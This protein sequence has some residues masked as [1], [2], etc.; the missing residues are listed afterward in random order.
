MGLLS[1]WLESLDYDYNILPHCSRHQSPRSSCTNCIDSCPENAIQLVNGKPKINS[2]KCTEC[3][4]CVASCPI[5]AVE[6]FLPKR[7]II[8]NQLIADD[9]KVPTQKELLAYYK[10]GVTTIVYQEQE[11]TSE[12]AE[13]IRKVN[14]I[15][16]KLGEEPFEVSSAC[17]KANQE[18]ALTRRELFYSWG[19]DLKQIAK[20]MTPAKWRF[21]H[22]SLDIAKYYPNYQFVDISLDTAKCTLCQ[23]CQKL[24]KKDALQISET[25]FTIVPQQCSDC[26]LCQDIC[27]ESAISI[28]KH[29]SI[30]ENVNHPVHEKVCCTCKK[31]FSTLC[32]EQDMCMICRKRKEYAMV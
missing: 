27:P 12:W 7:S 23:A 6:G 19:Q 4:E 21:N 3:G 25:D 29:I 28:K 22:E 2:T 17:V 31:A 20:D 32:E 26:G 10:K 16:E 24:C 15:L 8:N 30:A 11:I 5:Q 1:R 13:I 18:E 9:K 14:R